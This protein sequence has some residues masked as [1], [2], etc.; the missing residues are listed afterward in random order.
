MNKSNV[1]HQES[2]LLPL[3]PEYRAMTENAIIFVL[4][5]K[6]IQNVKG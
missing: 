5:H 6:N 1:F 3:P 4:L 2:F